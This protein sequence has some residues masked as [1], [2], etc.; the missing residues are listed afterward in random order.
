MKAFLAAAPSAASDPVIG[1]KNPILTTG[2]AAS[3]QKP[4]INMPAASRENKNAH[5]SLDLPDIFLFLLFHT[6]RIT[7]LM[8]QPG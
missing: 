8:N 3:A 5:N 2:S 4:P 6:V 1:P 7:R